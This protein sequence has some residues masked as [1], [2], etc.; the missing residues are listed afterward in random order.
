VENAVDRAAVPINDDAANLLDALKLEVIPSVVNIGTRVCPFALSV[1]KIRVGLTLPPL[2][3]VWNLP[4]A[5]ASDA[6]VDLIILVVS[7]VWPL[8]EQVLRKNELKSLLL[9]WIIVKS[10][11]ARDYSG[12][13]RRTS[14]A[15]YCLV[16]PRKINVFAC[17][18]NVPV[19]FLS[20]DLKVEVVTES[21]NI[22]A[23]VNLKQKWN[24]RRQIGER[25]G[26]SVRCGGLTL[27]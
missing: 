17:D 2:G 12:A 18:N 4:D 5:Q 7:N 26:C 9:V 19:F 15:G 16:E 8:R 20:N 21:V 25:L 23:R 6:D 1:S 22:Q 10:M 14:K 27:S 13:V 24:T 11:N 3:F